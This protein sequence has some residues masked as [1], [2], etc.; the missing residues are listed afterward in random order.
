MLRDRGGPPQMVLPL[1]AWSSELDQR[2]TSDPSMSAGAAPHQRREGGAMRAAH[3]RAMH[4]LGNP[5]GAPPSARRYR[6]E[7]VAGIE[8]AH[9]PRISA[10]RLPHA[11]THRGHITRRAGTPPVVKRS[12]HTL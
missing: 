9:P 3:A 2:G 8:L 5:R 6:E 10:A 1:S 12:L 11:V 7:G 4:S